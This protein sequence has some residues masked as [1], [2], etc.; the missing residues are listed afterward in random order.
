MSI[1]SEKP[2]HLD[3]LIPKVEDSSIF[4][5]KK[6][7]RIERLFRNKS[8]QMDGKVK[9]F[10]Q[11]ISRL[12]QELSKNCDHIR[13]LNSKIKGLEARITLTQQ[14]VRD[15]R[16]NDAKP[17][18]IEGIG[19]KALEPFKQELDK[20][21]KALKDYHEAWRACNAQING[22]KNSLPRNS[23]VS[24]LKSL[25]TL[26]QTQ[27]KLD[28]QFKAVRWKAELTEKPFPRHVTVPEAR[29]ASGFETKK[30][31]RVERLFR[32]RP[33]QLD[34]KS[35]ALNE[36]LN[37]VNK[38]LT[39][40][41]V[42]IKD[43]KNKIK[44]LERRIELANQAIGDAKKGNVDATIIEGINQ[45]SL[46]PFEEELAEALKELNQNQQSW[47]TFSAQIDE[48][49]AKLPKDRHVTALQSVKDLIQVQK[50]LAKELQ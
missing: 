26:S 29:E 24:G 28:S 37:D 25:K 50:N 40:K 45:K 8:K 42:Q 17:D 48:F 41:L 36:Q 46:K 9:D 35:Q 14:A 15:A 4:T 23:Q 13:A 6:V 19:V 1:P 39:D 32:K 18:I 43:L 21:L 27:K 38:A 2:F 20:E 31:G 49:I 12:N 33:K 30:V 11:K 16:S 22:L 10:D 5:K 3:H 7:G 47:N 44:G 34:D